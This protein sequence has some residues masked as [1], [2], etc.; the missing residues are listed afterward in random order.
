MADLP[1]NDP[2]DLDYDP[3]R[4]MVY[5]DGAFQ[6]PESPAFPA[7]IPAHEHIV[8]DDTLFNLIGHFSFGV[9]DTASESISEVE[10]P[11]TRTADSVYAML[12]P[13]GYSGAEIY[14]AFAF[15]APPDMSYDFKRGLAFGGIGGFL[16]GVLATYFFGGRR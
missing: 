2:Y 4:P 3:N 6:R 13:Q 7:T 10:V 12:Q 9:E 1:F 8:T 5:K 15:M 16:L 11:T 14:P